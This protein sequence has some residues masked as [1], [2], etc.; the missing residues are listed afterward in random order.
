MGGRLSRLRVQGLVGR[1]EDPR[2]LGEGEAP[3]GRVGRGSPLAPIKGQILS[4]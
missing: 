3:K 2:L 4:F 1:E